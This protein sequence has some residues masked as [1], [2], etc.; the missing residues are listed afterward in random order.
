MEK[1]TS[2]FY[3]E[4]TTNDKDCTVINVIQNDKYDNY[5][6]VNKN[7]YYN[8][9]IEL[10]IMIIIFIAWWPKGINCS[11]IIK[12]GHLFKGE[13]QGDGIMCPRDL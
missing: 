6:L 3:W 7:I 12:R 11:V 13:T 10:I 4:G 5:Q 1:I 2:R 8:V 9:V